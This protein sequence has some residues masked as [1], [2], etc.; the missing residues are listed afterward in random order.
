[1]GKLTIMKPPKQLDLSRNEIE[2]IHEAICV[3]EDFA[4]RGDE[5]AALALVWLRGWVGKPDG[6]VH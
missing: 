5:N 4:M 2:A 1:M 6:K 3:A